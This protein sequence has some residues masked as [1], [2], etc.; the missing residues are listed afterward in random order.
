MGSRNI[1]GIQLTVK[2]LEHQQGSI[3]TINLLSVIL[4]TTSK[5][6]KLNPKHP[7]NASSGHGA[8]GPHRASHTWRFTWILYDF[9]TI[10]FDWNQAVGII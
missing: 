9:T 1:L 5:H 2:K 8:M 10:L 7:P 6:Q 3:I 4:E